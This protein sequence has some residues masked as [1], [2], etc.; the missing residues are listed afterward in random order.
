MEGTVNCKSPPIRG[1]SVCTLVYVMDG[2]NLIG[3]LCV[4]DTHHQ[5]P[6][7][8]L[9]GGHVEQGEL[10]VM[11][12]ARETE[13][14]TGVAIDPNNLHFHADRV[15]SPKTNGE[16]WDVLLFSTRVQMRTLQLTNTPNEQG[17][18]AK[19]ITPNE[20][21]N[22]VRTGKFI[23]VHYQWIRDLLDPA[24]LNRRLA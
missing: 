4:V 9:P 15:K 12:A 5:D 10:P 18:L 23:E 3:Y 17:E 21:S 16:P 14:E 20:L 6:K 1:M 19:V 11:A 24:Q 2:E 7:Y 8:K 22:F 13:E